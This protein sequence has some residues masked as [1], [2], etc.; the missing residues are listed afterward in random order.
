LHDHS[1]LWQTIVDAG[2]K[3]FGNPQAKQLAW[4]LNRQEALQQLDALSTMHCRSSAIFKT[5]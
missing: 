1:D 4:P 2:V 3:S 5:R